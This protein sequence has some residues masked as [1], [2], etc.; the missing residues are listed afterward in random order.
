MTANIFYAALWCFMGWATYRG[1]HNVLAKP[2]KQSAQYKGRAVF[3]VL[4]AASMIWLAFALDVFVFG[5]PIFALPQIL[6]TVPLLVLSASGLIMVAV[7][8]WRGT[9]RFPQQ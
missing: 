9:F 5:A 4:L 7:E 2:A 8:F 6:W 1:F 3:F